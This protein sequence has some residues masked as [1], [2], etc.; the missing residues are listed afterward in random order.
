MHVGCKVSK[1]EVFSAISGKNVAGPKDLYRFLRPLEIQN[2][3]IIFPAFFCFC[4][5]E[6]GVDVQIT[7]DLLCRAQKSPRVAFDSQRLFGSFFD[8]ILRHLGLSI[9]S[10]EMFGMLGCW[11]ARIYTDVQIYF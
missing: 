7:F 2:R 8:F 1:S 11:D 5:K 3:Y 9:C 4:V 10:N 6:V